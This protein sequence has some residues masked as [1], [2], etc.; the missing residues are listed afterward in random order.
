MGVPYGLKW[1]ISNSTL[2]SV[3]G[4]EQPMDRV[5]YSGRYYQSAPFEGTFDWYPYMA[6]IPPF[7]SRI[8][9]L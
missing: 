5:A 1:P 6:A 8:Q 2:S 4:W 3:I 7:P 9:R